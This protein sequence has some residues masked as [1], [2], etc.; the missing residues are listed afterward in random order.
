LLESNEVVVL[1]R[2][3]NRALLVRLVSNLSRKSKTSS[4]AI[5]FG[6]YVSSLTSSSILTSDRACCSP[7]FDTEAI[8]FGPWLK[9]RDV[10]RLGNDGVTDV[11]PSGID[12]VPRPIH[13][14]A[15]VAMGLPL[16]DVLDLE[17]VSEEA[18]GGAGGSSC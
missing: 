13:Q 15:I 9:Q 14:L 5:R 18:P 2:I 7:E 11:Q 17:A 16:V 8:L 4:R 12:S 10:A 1:T 6:C 3:R